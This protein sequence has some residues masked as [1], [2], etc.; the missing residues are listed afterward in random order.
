MTVNDLPFACY[1]HD[2]MIAKYGTIYV[3]RN[4]GW[5]TFCSNSH[6]IKE[7]QAKD[8]PLKDSVEA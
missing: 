3:N 7:V 5:M 4:D 8:F 6:I 1:P 2:E